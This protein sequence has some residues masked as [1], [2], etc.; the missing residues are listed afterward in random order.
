MTLWQGTRTGT[1]SLNTVAG[2]E[3]I[4]GRG[5]TNAKGMPEYSSPRLET[6]E[7]DEKYGYYRNDYLGE[8]R[9]V[10]VTQE[11]LLIDENCC[12]DQRLILAAVA[13][14]EKLLEWFVPR[15]EVFLILS[16]SRRKRVRASVS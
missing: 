14:G 6:L 16:L 5:F 13:A 15:I 8:L 2:T 11:E 10:R 4:S 3:R 9:L 12:S 1:T 7:F